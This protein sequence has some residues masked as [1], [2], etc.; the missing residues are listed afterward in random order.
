VNVVDPALLTA[1]VPAAEF[2][3][4]LPQTRVVATAGNPPPLDAPAPVAPAR[5]RRKYRH[6]VPERFGRWTLRT[7]L[8]TGGNAEVWQAEDVES[9][10]V[11]AIKIVHADRTDDD[12]YA[13][14]R[15]EVDSINELA[16]E[17][18]RVLPIIDYY[19][20]EDLAD[21]PWYVMP[22]AVPI[23]SALARASVVDRVAAFAELADELAHLAERLAPP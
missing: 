20:P 21:A 9:G 11:A 14:F 22:V 5:R 2:A 19:L 10:E 15:R 17:G 7:Q 8:G 3:A 18:V 16:G 13:R 1:G 6:R 12:A 23:R 4:H